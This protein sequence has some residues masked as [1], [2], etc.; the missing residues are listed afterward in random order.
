[1]GELFSRADDGANEMAQWIRELAAKPNDV[2]P[3]LRTHMVEE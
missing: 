1:M 2:S 3:I